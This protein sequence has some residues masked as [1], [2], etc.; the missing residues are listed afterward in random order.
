[1]FPQK[2]KIDAFFLSLGDY[3]FVF[4]G[5]L[6]ETTLLHQHPYMYIESNY[7]LHSKHTHSHQHEIFLIKDLFYINIKSTL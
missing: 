6:L 1:M 7:P 5:Y 4:L 3:A 2:L